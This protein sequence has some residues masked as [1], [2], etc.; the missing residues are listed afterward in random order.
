MTSGDNVWSV[1]QVEL[2]ITNYQVFC[3]YLAFIQIGLQYVGFSQRQ[4]QTQT[5]SSTDNSSLT[6]TIISQQLKPHLSGGGT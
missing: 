1:I 4:T 3:L 6:L 2:A 5:F